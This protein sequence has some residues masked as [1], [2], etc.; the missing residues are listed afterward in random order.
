M[1]AY[2]VAGGQVSLLHRG[3][4]YD[5]AFEVAC[6]NCIGCRIE[7]ARQWAVRLMH[8]NECHEDSCF[9]T[10]TYD[11]DHL[12]PLD[13]LDVR[14]WQL[15]AKAVRRYMG[16]RH[17]IDPSLPKSFRFYHCGE[18]GE[19]TLR[20]HYHALVFGTAFLEDR[21]LVKSHPS[22][23]FASDTLDRLWG[24][25]NCWIGD[26]TYASA[27][28][29]A[30]YILKKIKGELADSHYAVVNEATGEVLG[31]R[32]P[33]YSTMSRRPGIGKLWLD[34]FGDQV[35]PR[36][37]VIVKGR[38]VRPPKYYDKQI[39]KEQPDLEE[40]LRKK[41]LTGTAKY[42]EHQTRERRDVRHEKAQLDRRIFLR[43]PEDK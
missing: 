14:H 4:F 37:E 32:K 7:H 20:P 1:P 28:Y 24:R 33:E 25:G 34:R 27:N 10:L 39:F 40:R 3:G 17:K 22:R 21:R 36:D 12:P 9:I 15:F 23:L 6:G 8:E 11:D 38:A 29:V 26:V 43:E 2:R 35:Y 31:H 13:S 18:Y 19:R 5:K 42:A 16:N 30:G 41:R